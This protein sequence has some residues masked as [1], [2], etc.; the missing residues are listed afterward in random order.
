M[1]ALLKMVSTLNL[2]LRFMHQFERMRI[3]IQVRQG[4]KEDDIVKEHPNA[5]GNMDK[6]HS[7]LF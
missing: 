5:P 4:D 1:S 6:S 2:G 3:S 7:A